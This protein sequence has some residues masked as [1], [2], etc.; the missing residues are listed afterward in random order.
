ML[1]YS[2]SLDT[3]EVDEGMKS[4]IRKT[5]ELSRRVLSKLSEAVV[6]RTVVHH[7][8]G[9]TLNRGTGTLAKSINYRLANDFLSLVRSNVAYAAI[10][11]FGGVIKAKNA[12]ALHFKVGDRW[13]MVKQVVMPKRSYL[14]PSL[15]WVFENS[16]EDIM[17]DEV[18]EWL[19]KRW[20]K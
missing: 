4:L 20:Y 9:Q 6:T 3:T 10:H 11:E 16:A 2:Y 12:G 19:L 18:S 5:P 1:G 8:S 15:D 14:K 17:N 7:L 13:V